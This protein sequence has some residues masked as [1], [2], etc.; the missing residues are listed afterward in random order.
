MHVFACERRGGTHQA[1]RN[2][3]RQDGCVFRKRAVMYSGAAPS[4]GRGKSQR[5][6]VGESERERERET[7]QERAGSSVSERGRRERREQGGERKREFAER[8]HFCWRGEK[9]LWKLHQKKT[10]TRGRTKEVPMSA[11]KRA[12][13][14]LFTA[15]FIGALTYSSLLGLTLHNSLVDSGQQGF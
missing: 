6:G 8:K 10:K 12:S 9:Q 14:V 7:E 2:P 3:F 11:H 4:W 15:V 13:S 1:Q 5:W